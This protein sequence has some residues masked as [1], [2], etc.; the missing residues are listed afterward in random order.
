M[1]DVIYKQH[2]QPFSF[3][4]DRVLKTV[5]GPVSRDYN[6]DTKS[7]GT[8]IRQMCLLCHA[9]IKLAEIAIT[10]RQETRGYQEVFQP[11]QK[12]LIELGQEQI[13]RLCANLT[14]FDTH[15]LLP[16]CNTM[17]LNEDEDFNEPNIALLKKGLLLKQC[18]L[19]WIHLHK[20]TVSVKKESLDTED[21]AMGLLQA[22]STPPAKRAQCCLQ[23]LRDDTTQRIS[24]TFESL[25]LKSS[26]TEAP[27]LYASFCDNTF[28]EWLQFYY[29][30]NQDREITNLLDA[31]GQLRE[32]LKDQ[33]N[34][35]ASSLSVDQKPY[36]LWGSPY[37]LDDYTNSPAI[38]SNEV[39]AINLILAKMANFKVKQLPPTPVSGYTLMKNSTS[40]TQEEA[41][42]S[43][44]V[45]PA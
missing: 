37:S 41:S 5:I 9:G 2:S 34:K 29:N 39:L 18:L 11:A 31:L 45:S 21:N 16:T 7:L 44:S 26:K 23:L 12:W 27:M 6:S 38:S 10:S 43:I 19:H 17:L 4:L 22:A 15:A 28:L 1:S 36:A 25:L 8:F 40:T 35:T 32:A 20:L 24:T 14:H 13:N 33:K 42:H 3:F 30:H